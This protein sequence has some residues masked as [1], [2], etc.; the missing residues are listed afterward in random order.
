MSIWVGQFVSL[1]EEYGIAPEIVAE[2]MVAAGMKS[3]SVEA[4]RKFIEENY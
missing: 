2:D 3:V 1:C 4:V